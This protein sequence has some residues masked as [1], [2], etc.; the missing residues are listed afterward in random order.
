MNN[1]RGFITIHSNAKSRKE[2]AAYLFKY[3]ILANFLQ[4]LEAGAV[5][6][7]LL[8]LSD[9]FSMGHF[10]QGLL[11]GIVYIALSC[12]GPFAGWLLRRCDHRTVVGT[13]VILNNFFTLVWA[14]TPL[15]WSF[16]KKMFIAVRFVMGLFQCVL[17]VFLPLWINEY[18]PSD[19]RTSWMGFLQVIFSFKSEYIFDHCVRENTMSWLLLE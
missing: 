16:S 15:H 14:F 4:Y 12:G 9:D 1:R 18:A 5:P 17:C 7:L 13:A 8:N 2:N 10:E 6:A 19:R 11:G 3:F